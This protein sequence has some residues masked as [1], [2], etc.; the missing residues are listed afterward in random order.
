MNKGLLLISVLLSGY[1][2][3]DS[4]WS[5]KPQINCLKREHS[6][7][8]IEWKSA[9]ANVSQKYADKAHIR[10]KKIDSIIFEDMT[11]KLRVC[12]TR[13]AGNFFET[14]SQYMRVRIKKILRFENKGAKFGCALSHNKDW[15]SVCCLYKIPEKQNKK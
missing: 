6:N 3:C 5:K 12:Y 14:C 1:C 8:G 4:G 13:L 11:K 7:H 2:K 10:R 15:I 9:L